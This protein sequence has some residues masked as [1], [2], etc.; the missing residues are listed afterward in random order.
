TFVSDLTGSAS[1]PITVRVAPGEHAVIDS[2]PSTDIALTITGAWTTYWDLDVMSSSPIRVSDQTGSHVT[3]IG[4]GTGVEVR[5][6]HT[7]VIDFVLHDL[8]TGM[9]M[10]SD[11]EDAEAYGNIVFNN[12]WTAPDRNH[13]HG[14]YTQN[15]LPTRRITDNIVFNQFG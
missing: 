2:A 7:K 11:A 9:G 4:R 5:G 1:A 13:G 12:G 3:D 10:W 8:T 6:P 15:R 14:I